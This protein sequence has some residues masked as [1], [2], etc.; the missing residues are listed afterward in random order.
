MDKIGIDMRPVLAE[1][2]EITPISSRMITE[3]QFFFASLQEMS[4]LWFSSW[5]LRTAFSIHFLAK[6]KKLDGFNFP[7]ACADITCR[8]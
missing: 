3:L 2:L 1:T 7:T 6:T 4:G 5:E 8:V